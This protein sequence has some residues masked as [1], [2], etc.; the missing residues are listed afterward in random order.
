V[1][2]PSFRRLAIEPLLELARRSR[3]RTLEKS[4]KQAVERIQGKLRGAE[5]GQLSL[6]ETAEHEGGLS[7]AEDA[8]GGLSAATA[9]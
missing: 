7:P 5:H 1:S 3:S 4:I 6:A 2:V 8:E 9:D